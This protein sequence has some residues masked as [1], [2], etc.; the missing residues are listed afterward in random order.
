[1]GLLTN[2]L[3]FPVTGP[4]AG[5]KWSLGKVQQVV[6]EELTDDTPVKQDLME[7]QM[8]LELG[9]IDDAEYV[10]REA[11]IMQRLREVRAWRERFGKGTSGGPVRVA[12]DGEPPAGD[13]GEE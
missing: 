2:L 3:F 13:S 12:R 7:L 6:E 4:V 10:R 11:E 1:M 5:I 8:Q 9:D